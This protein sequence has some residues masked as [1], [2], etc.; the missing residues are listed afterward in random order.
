VTNYGS[1]NV[2]AYTVNAK[3]GALTPVA[4]SPFGAGTN[5]AGSTG[6]TL[7]NTDTLDVANKGSNN[8]SAYTIDPKS[9]ALTPVAGSPFGAGTGP[10]GVAVIQVGHSDFAYVVNLGSN[11][12]SAYTVRP[13]KRRADAGGGVAVWGGHKARWRGSGPGR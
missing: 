9:G 13:E 5:P 6:G 12:V 7:G 1:D 3:S 8:V 10:V 11:N 4:G 2:S